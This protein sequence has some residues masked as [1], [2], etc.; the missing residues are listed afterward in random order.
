MLPAEVWTRP[1][2]GWINEQQFNE[3]E[4]W[5]VFRGIVSALA[6][7]GASLICWAGC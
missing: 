7:L 3:D 5:E 4:A 2:A 6:M 1:A